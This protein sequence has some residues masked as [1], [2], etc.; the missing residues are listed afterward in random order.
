MSKC[1]E[2]GGKNVD[3][4]QLERYDADNE[5]KEMGVVLVDA[6]ER[7]KCPDCKATWVN[8]PD[9][10][11]LLAAVAVYRV[12]A[13]LKLSGHEIKFL[14]KVME[15]SAKEFAALLEVS[16]ETVSRWE[17]DKAPMGPANEKL[18]RL[19]TVFRLK[20][21]AP[22]VPCPPEYISKM[23]ISPLRNINAVHKMT[24]YYMQALLAADREP[25]GVWRE[26]KRVA[27]G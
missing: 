11:G 12:M 27:N 24:L 21:S 17:N 10:P 23:K 6:V 26:Q 3:T 19:T 22:G 14:R 20:D 13:P 1:K 9:L 16:Q 8:I 7:H 4:E 18:L 5:L 25:E 2:C 15:I